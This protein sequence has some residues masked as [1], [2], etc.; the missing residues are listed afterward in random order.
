MK[1]FNFVEFLLS[2]VILIAVSFKVIVP[3][4]MAGNFS[5]A[6][7]RFDRMK[8]TSPSSMYVTFVPAGAGTVAKVKL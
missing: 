5:R 4:V 1:K 8:T 3:M 2:L 6:T 7:I